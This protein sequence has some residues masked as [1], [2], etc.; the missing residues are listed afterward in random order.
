MRRTIVVSTVVL[1]LAL[2]GGLAQAQSEYAQLAGVNSVLFNIAEAVPPP[3]PLL[4]AKI[5]HSNDYTTRYRS[6]GTR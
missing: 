6:R 1:A 5:V 4:R 3:A 2:T